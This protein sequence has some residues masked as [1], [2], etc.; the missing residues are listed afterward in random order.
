[1]LN[2]PRFLNQ[3]I[4]FICKTPT[5]QSRDDPTMTDQCIYDKLGS[6]GTASAR[7]SPARLQMD[8]H[9]IT[10]WIEIR[11]NKNGSLMHKSKLN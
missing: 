5:K 7:S 2:E 3:D 11:L 8:D 1:M 9:K 10:P 4:D 6:D